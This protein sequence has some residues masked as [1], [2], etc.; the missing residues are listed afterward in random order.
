[1]PFYRLGKMNFDSR[2]MMADAGQSAGITTGEKEDVNVIRVVNT[3]TNT[4]I[5]T[6]YPMKARRAYRQRNM[7]LGGGFCLKSCNGIRAT[8]L[9]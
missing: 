4:P 2:T 8:A 1:M 7:L 6:I 3:G 5:S 9:P